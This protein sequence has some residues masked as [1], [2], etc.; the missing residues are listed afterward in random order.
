MTP[1]AC[2]VVSPEPFDKKTVNR[3]NDLQLVIYRANRT[4]ERGVED[5][6][7]RN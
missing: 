5:E 1:I 7:K 2:Y 3:W 4:V 6:C